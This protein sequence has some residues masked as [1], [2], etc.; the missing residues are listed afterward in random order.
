MNFIKGYLQPGLRDTSPPK[1]TARPL[2]EP[3]QHAVAR[4]AVVGA[5]TPSPFDSRMSTPTRSLRPSSYFPE[6][7]F[8]NETRQSV[9]DIKGNVMVNW[10]HQQQLERL[11]ASGA[12][13]EGVVL[14][15]E[16][17]S[18]TCSPASLTSSPTGFYDRVIEMNVRVSGLE[19]RPCAQ[20]TDQI[21]TSV[22]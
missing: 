9:L 8:R 1:L 11:W 14:K 5:E 20:K 13:G 18:F 12:P 3:G 15:K 22:L 10:L 17:D 19:L 4:T 21:K 16:R 6:G 2:G 7:D